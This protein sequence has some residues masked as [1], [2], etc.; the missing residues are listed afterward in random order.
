MELRRIIM[1]YF[2]SIFEFENRD[3]VLPKSVLLKIAAE[4]R[5]SYE[6]YSHPKRMARYTLYRDLIERINP[7]FF[8][9]LLNCSH[10]CRSAVINYLLPAFF[11][12]ANLKVG[13]AS[14][15]EKNQQISQQIL[16][17][18]PRIFNNV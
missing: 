10:F 13:V 9:N 18:F 2:A 4:V 15:F 7:G 3:F 6:E 11:D 5:K 14:Y 16:D 1:N 12:V 8:D 17:E